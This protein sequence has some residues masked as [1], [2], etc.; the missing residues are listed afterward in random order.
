[1]KIIKLIFVIA[2]WVAAVLLLGATLAGVVKPSSLIW[3]SLLSYGFIPLLLLNV[4]FVVGWL[5]CGSKQFLVSA[6]VILLRFTFIPACFQIGGHPDGPSEGA[7]TLKVT[8]FNVHHFYGPKYLENGREATNIE[9]N[10][11]AFLDFV[12]SENSDLL[13]I[14]EFLPYTKKI[15]VRD[16]LR[17]MGYHYHVLASPLG[18]SSL[19]LWSRYPIVDTLYIDSVCKMRAGIVVNEDTLSFYC[20]HL[21]SYRLN[22][23][24]KE[25]IDLIASGDLHKASLRQTV[26]KFK[27]T[28][29]SHEKEW[30]LLN[31]IMER[32]YHRMIVAGDFNDTPASYVYL[33]MTDILRDCYRDKGKGFGTTY[34]GQFPAFRIDYIMHSAGLKTLSY[35]R[36]KSDISDHYPITVEFEIPGRK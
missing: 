21:A 8:N 27:Q 22:N 25:G 12:R 26:S 18:R 14:E 24:D 4:L 35:Q 15:D 19:A 6:I 9:N 29:L 7:L 16:S 36:V 28:I 31:P 17:N 10:I 1:M 32:D 11:T 3:P 34:R 33:K 23:D 5:I 30:S 2:N 13:C 20:L